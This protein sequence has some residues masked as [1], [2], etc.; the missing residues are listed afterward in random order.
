MKIERV[1]VQVVAPEVK[2]PALS[3]MSKKVSPAGIAS[4]IVIPVASLGPVFVTV[5]E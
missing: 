2:R 4:V 1:K 5:I 3:R